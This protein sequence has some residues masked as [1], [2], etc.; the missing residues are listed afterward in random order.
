M[1][2]ALAD[3]EKNLKNVA[4]AIYKITCQIF[5]FLYNKGNLKKQK[6]RSH[7]GRVR[8]LGE[9]VGLN[10]PRGFESRPLRKITPRLW[11][12]LFL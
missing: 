10:G 8:L 5:F 2:R 6:E 3:Q 11:G 9:Q 1:I 4:A 12:L 7:S